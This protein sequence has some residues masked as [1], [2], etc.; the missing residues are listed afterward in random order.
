MKNVLLAFVFCFTLSSCAVFFGDNYNNTKKIQ[1]L[2]L[3]M[4]KDEAI[5]VMGNKYIIESSSIEEDGT[6]EVIKYDAQTDVPYLLHFLNGELVVF[7]RYYPP[8]VPEQ[9]VVI[10]N[11]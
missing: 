3:G 5:R 11:E 9:K 7:N 4:S 6:L 1:Q 10:K 2:Q 8:Y